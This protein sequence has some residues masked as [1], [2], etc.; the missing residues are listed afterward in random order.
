MQ[1][2]DCEVHF[3]LR[4]GSCAVS[5]IRDVAKKAGVSIST[6]SNVINGTKFVSP[7]LANKVLGAASALSYQANPMARSMKTGRS[8][9]IGV[10]TADIS[11]LFYPYVL[12]G[13]CEVADRNDYSVSIADAGIVYDSDQARKRELDCFKSLIDNRVDG[14]I[15]ASSIG[16]QDASEFFEEQRHRAD[17]NK[18]IALVSIE[19]NFTHHGID[20]IY[21]DNV[22]G[23]QKAVSH[24]LECGCNKIVHIAG[25]PGAQVVQS[26][27][28]GYLS[29]L[30][31]AGYISLPEMI[32]YG[33]YS[34]QSGYL[35]MEQLITSNPDLDGV[36]VAND[37]MAIGAYQSL[38]KRKIDIPEK[39]K[40]VG[41]DDVFISGL[42]NPS[43]TSVHVRKKHLGARAAQV[44]LKNIEQPSTGKE[45]VFQEELETVLVVRN[46]TVE[47]LENNWAFSDW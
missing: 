31:S 12:K 6:V 29:T 40:V 9:T 30:Q 43:L 24:L 16:E 20:S 17:I 1:I 46:S 11:G 13:I 5:N 27:I 19:R 22:A 28:R 15:F 10:V 8:R 45:T 25:P 4:K 34:H 2:P 41:F 42:V 37:Q 3:I 14:I 39:V 7:E 32:A 35:A 21:Y 36:F 33:D 23:A 44:A 18:Q 47:G 26:R 38:Q